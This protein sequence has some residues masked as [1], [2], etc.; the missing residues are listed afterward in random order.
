MEKTEG[1]LTLAKGAQKRAA[2][3]EGT[4]NTNA[5]TYQGEGAQ[6]FNTVLPFE[7]GEVNSPQGFGQPTVNA[8]TTQAGQATSGATGA[9]NEQAQL[10]ASRT[11]NTAALPGIIDATARS[12]MK[13]QSNNA[14]DVGIANE[15]EKLQQQQQGAQGLTSLYGTGTES[16]LKSLGLADQD[17]NSWTNAD[18]ENPWKSLLPGLVGAGA[19]AAIGA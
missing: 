2:E 14:L 4:N 7:Q 18:A 17:I 9:A 5:G 3:L 12:G 16:A 6:A 13:Q 10:L 19:K 11:G 1:G 15:K 8:L